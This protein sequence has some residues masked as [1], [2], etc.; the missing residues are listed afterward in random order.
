MDWGAKS[1]IR[2]GV[3]EVGCQALYIAIAIS[4]TITVIAIY[5]KIDRVEDRLREQLYKIDFHNLE[6]LLKDR[7][8]EKS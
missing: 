1:N 2:E 4:C 3:R 6:L 8:S 7:D 5:Q